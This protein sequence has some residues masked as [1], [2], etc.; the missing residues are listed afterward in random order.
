MR[1]EN[2]IAAKQFCIY[3][4][5]EDTF[6]ADLQ[7]AGIIQIKVVNQDWYIP[8]SELQKLERLTRL[9]NELEIN[10]AGIEA[11]SHLL[12]R[13]ED[14]QTEMQQLRNRLTAYE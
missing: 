11:I 8:E 4:E 7:Q 10:T 1:T 13:I 3:H 12:Q 14:I 9:H 2:L 6:I 5:V